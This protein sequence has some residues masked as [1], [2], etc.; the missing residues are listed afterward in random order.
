MNILL[1]ILAIVAIYY[2]VK[3]EGGSAGGWGQ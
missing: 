2:L 1:T 3:T